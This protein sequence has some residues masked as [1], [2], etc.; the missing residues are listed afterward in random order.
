[1]QVRWKTLH[2]LI[3]F[4]AVGATISWNKIF[5]P[6]GPTNYIN[7]AFH[8]SAAIETPNQQTRLLSQLTDVKCLVGCSC[9][10]QHNQGTITPTETLHP[11]VTTFT[12]QLHTYLRQHI[13]RALTSKDPTMN[14]ISRWICQ[15]RIVE[16]TRRP[17]PNSLTNEVGFSANKTN[18]L[19]RIGW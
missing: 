5:R 7:D 8:I 12:K 16:Y 6:C 13:Q 15:H 3:I 14:V 11:S 10:H 1:M 17:W 9:L 19:N 18:L 2:A 4:C